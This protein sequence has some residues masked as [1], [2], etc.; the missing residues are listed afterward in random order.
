MG[1]LFDGVA[2]LMGVRQ[3]VNY[4]AQ[5]AMELEALARWHIDRVDPTRY[6]FDITTNASVEIGTRSLIGNLVEDV[7]AGVDRSIMAA[8]FHHA[9]ARMVDQVCHLIRDATGIGDVGLTGGVFQNALLLQLAE[10]A[11]LASGFQ[12]YTHRL[13]PANDGG[14]ALGQA[15]T[16]SQGRKPSAGP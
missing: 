16:A 4:E 14:I 7:A 6:A 12:V 2:A 3:V 10:D 15:W 13:V 9:V 5:A 11:L 8:C 1:R